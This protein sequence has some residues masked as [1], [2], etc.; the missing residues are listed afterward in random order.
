MLNVDWTWTLPVMLGLIG[1]V[2]SLVADAL[3]VIFFVRH[4]RK[5]NAA[6]RKAKQ[7]KKD[8]DR[9]L[10]EIKEMTEKIAKIKAKRGLK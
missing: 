9:D 8:L 4:T 7:D 1:F 2:L 3:F 10:A 5:H 6:E